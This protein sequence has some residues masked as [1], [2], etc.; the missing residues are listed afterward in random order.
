MLRRRAVLRGVDIGLPVLNAYA[1][2]KRLRL[3]RHALR[4]QHFKR[5][6]RAV[7]AR[8]YQ[9]FT[10][11]LI[12]A[13]RTA[14]AHGMQC[15]VLYYKVAQARTEPHLAAQFD[16]SFAYTPYH[17]AQHVGAYMRLGK[18]QRLGRCAE[19]N[20][21]FSHPAAAPIL[22]T[23]GQLAVRERARAALAK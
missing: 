23:R 12:F 14:H 6:A 4:M 5:V 9:R 10:A 15:A 11:Q 18:V 7:A 13:L 3:H 17:A 21:L 1:H 16:N 19:L 20:Q 2:G 8:Q 22:Y